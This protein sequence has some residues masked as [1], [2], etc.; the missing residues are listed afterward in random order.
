VRRYVIT[1]APG[2]GKTALVE[3]L[4]HVTTV[5]GEPARELIVEHREATGEPSLDGSPEVF[6]E[7]LILRSIEKFD[8]ATD[9]KATF[10]DRGLPDCVAYA[11]VFGVDAGPA[12]AASSVRRYTDP[13]FVAPPW[14]SIYS[15]DDMRRASFAQIVVFHNELV[16]AYHALGYKLL[17]LPKTTVTERVRFVTRFLQPP[18]TTGDRP[19]GSA[20]EPG[21]V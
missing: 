15:V 18:P 14:E 3:S 20:S 9:S 17:E 19:T 16:A 13:V 1:G 6:V 5:G 7:R 21:P 10:Y 4:A 12:I 8:A 2:T 11:R